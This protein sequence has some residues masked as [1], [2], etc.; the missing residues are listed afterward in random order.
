ML[1]AAFNLVF[2]LYW[3][4]PATH[5]TALS[6]D[7]SQLSRSMAPNSRVLGFRKFYQQ[8]SWFLILFYF[9][10]FVRAFCTLI[11]LRGPRLAC[12]LRIQVDDLQIFFTNWSFLLLCRL[13]VPNSVWRL[14]LNKILNSFLCKHPCHWLS[15]T[16]GW[17]GIHTEGRIRA[18]LIPF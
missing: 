17:E 14:E 2:W 5:L 12:H 8:H 9:P 16:Q 15:L 10:V 6:A 7:I 3:E 4:S 11:S 18:W 13:I 1:E